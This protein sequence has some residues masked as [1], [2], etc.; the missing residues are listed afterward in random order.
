MRYANLRWTDVARR[1]KDRVLVVCPLGSIEQHGHHLPLVTD[2][3]LVT[4]VAEGVEARLADRLLLAP[5][6]WLGASDHHLD[7]PGTL[8][9]PNSLYVA[10]IKNVVRSLVR[11]GFTRMLL[12]NGHGG[13]IAPGEV[14]IAEAANE[15]DQCDRAIVALASYWT[16]AAAAMEPHRHGM[17]SPRLTH[18]CEYETSLMLHL[19]RD[20]VAIDSARGEASAERQ[21][22]PGTFVAGRFRRR[23]S[24]GALGRP[25][26]ATADKGASLLA[27]ITDEVT[28]LAEQMLK[29][30]SRGEHPPVTNV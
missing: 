16:V 20:L 28:A 2:T 4:A 15:C 1:E 5:T 23:T 9:V 7:F 25:D 10:M 22:S 26:R 18:A 30:P 6:L 17:E 29:W 27:A 12:L 13:N 14:A 19:H 21:E 24:T 3:A 11:A 8:S